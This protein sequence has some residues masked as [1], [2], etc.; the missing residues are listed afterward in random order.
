MLCA[1][2][3]NHRHQTS[4]VTTAEYCAFQIREC[5]SG[6][7]TTACILKARFVEA[8]GYLPLASLSNVIPTGQKY[9]VG[10]I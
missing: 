10:R 8:L 3:L 1:M 7:R 5:V 6:Q 4:P 2:A 9:S